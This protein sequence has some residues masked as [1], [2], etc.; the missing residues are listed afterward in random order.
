[1]DQNRIHNPFE[2]EVFTCGVAYL[3]LYVTWH[4][5]GNMDLSSEYS[6]R[7]RSVMERQQRQLLIPGMG[8]YVLDD[9]CQEIQSETGWSV[10]W[11]VAQRKAVV[12]KPLQ[13]IRG[14][15]RA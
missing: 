15:G 8:T 6:R 11:E 4:R 9:V 2:E 13:R 7:A 10:E 1:L 5:L 3:F 14:E 12:A